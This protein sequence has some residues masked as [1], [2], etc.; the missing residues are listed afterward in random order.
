VTVYAVAGGT[1]LEW[2]SRL[3][4]TGGS[5]TLDGDPFHAGFQFRAQDDVYSRP[6]ETYFLRTDGKGKLGEE[7]NGKT[8]TGLPWEAMSFMLDRTRYTV[9]YI[10]SPRDPKPSFYVERLYGRFGS[11]TGKQT[12]KEGEAPLELTYRVW[13]QEGEMTVE[14]AAA[15]SADFA[16]P[17][18]TTAVVEK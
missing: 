8:M 5:V 9:A 3:R 13:L 1:L 18:K 17:P 14:R 11:W 6:K 12:L 15:L 2:S 7:R 4:S 16:E 10:D